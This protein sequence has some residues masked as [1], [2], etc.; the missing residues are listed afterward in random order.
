M[1]CSAEKSVVAAHSINLGHTLAMNRENGF[2]LSWA[3]KPLFRD[4]KER[5]QSL[6]KE[7]NPILWWPGK[8]RLLLSY[9]PSA[10]TPLMP[11]WSLPLAEL[12]LYLIPSWLAHSFRLPFLLPYIIPLIPITVTS[13]WRWRQCIS[14]KQWHLQTS[15]HGTRTQK[16]IFIKLIYR[17]L[18]R[19][20]DISL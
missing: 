17:S 7:S 4:L 6:T 10:P 1:L 3:W 16:N 9:P 18:Y 20:S 12:N 11:A 14:L 8:G 5:R 13:A 15:P 19:A 2:S